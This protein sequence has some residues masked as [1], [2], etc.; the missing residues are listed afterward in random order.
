MKELK[1]HRVM[2]EMSSLNTV[3]IL[4]N[5]V[6]TGRTL[7][8]QR[9]LKS[10]N[11]TA[12]SLVIFLGV[13]SP[14]G[15]ADTAISHSSPSS[16]SSVSSSSDIMSTASENG[17]NANTLSS[18]SSTFALSAQQE[19]KLDQLFKNDKVDNTTTAAIS[20]VLPLSPDQVEAF[21]KRNAAVAFAQ[22]PDPISL[23]QLQGTIRSINLLNN[24]TPPLI[25][26]VQNYATNISFVGENGQAWPIADIVPGSDAIT[27]SPSYKTDPYNSTIIVMKPWISTN[28]TYY[29]KGRVKPIVLFIHTALDT[30]QGLDAS[31]TV[32]VNG[33]SPG[34]SPLPIKNVGAVSDSL[35]NAV[36]NAP[37][38][39]WQPVPLDN[40]NLPVGLKMWT[41][42]DRKSAIVRVTSGQL[43]S[44]DWQSQASNPDNTVTAYSFKYVPLML[45]V[46][47]NDGQNFQVR[48]KQAIE[49]LAGNEPSVT[50][51]KAQNI[52]DIE[53]AAEERISHAQ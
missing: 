30:K 47:S 50:S 7:K 6:N 10:L 39:Q 49:T 52:S 16:D 13:Y 26:L 9:Y 18:L 23:S 44:P 15:L 53:K 25:H 3:H 31:V 41:S 34:T 48:M 12:I 28:V 42:P 1:E 33:L 45:L 8:I 24:S 17:S 14:I 11:Y 19:K 27:A 32:S 5:R 29:L 40:N 35:L 38:N 36:N 20:K 2:N 43:V 46:N 37:G 4:K 51:M 21:K 22:E